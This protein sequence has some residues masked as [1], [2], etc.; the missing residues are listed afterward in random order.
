MASKS[1]EMKP[2]LENAKSKL[3]SFLAYLVMNSIGRTCRVT[4]V[5]EGL[6]KKAKEK[7]KSVIYAFWHGRQFILIYTHRR[8][9]ICIMTSFSKD[10][11]LQ[12]NIITRMGYHPVRGSHQ[13]R[14]AIEGTLEMIKMA[15]EGKDIA[16]AGDG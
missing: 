4:I 3:L 8:R 14:G 15:G 2:F 13:K 9:V 16:F 1:Q 11:E 10:G 12:T 6:V 7:S 5:N